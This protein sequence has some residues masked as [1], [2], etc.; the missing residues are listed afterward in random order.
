MEQL[1]SSET[2]RGKDGE[3]KRLEATWNRLV[4]KEVDR[5]GKSLGFSQ[6]GCIAYTIQESILLHRTLCLEEYSAKF[7]VCAAPSIVLT[8][9]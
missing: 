2:L 3:K 7:L 8:N 6:V 5:S 1:R 9:L 4:N